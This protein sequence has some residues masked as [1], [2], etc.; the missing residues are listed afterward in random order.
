MQYQLNTGT[1]LGKSKK[2]NPKGYTKVG[3]FTTTTQR[4]ENINKPDH[5]K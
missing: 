2:K 3:K 1:K 5:A 4:K